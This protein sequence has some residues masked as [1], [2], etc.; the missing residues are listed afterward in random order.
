[1]ALVETLREPI[2]RTVH[3]MVYFFN[4]L[5]DKGRLKAFSVDI[6][7]KI[8]EKDTD[9]ERITRTIKGATLTEVSKVRGYYPF[10]L[11]VLKGRQYNLSLR[12]EG[13]PFFDGGDSQTIYHHC[14]LER[15]IENFDLKVVSKGSSLTG[16]IYIPNEMIDGRLRVNYS[17]DYEDDYPAGS[18]GDLV[19]EGR[20][21]LLFEETAAFVKRR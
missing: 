14:I 21:D 11:Q 17:Q 5:I 6:D 13:G 10:F 3:E 20:T 4:E 12:S 16:D 18:R 15:L 7:K 9:I 2:G 1:M 19:I 8:V